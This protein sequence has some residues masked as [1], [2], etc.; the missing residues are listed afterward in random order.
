MSRT[1]RIR[2]LAVA[3]A[4]GVIVFPAWPAD[5]PPRRAV[6]ARQK[7]ELRF[8]S[9]MAGQGLWREALFRWERLAGEIPADPRLWNNIAVAREALGD[10]EGARSAYRKALDLEPETHIQANAALQARP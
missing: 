4:A 5:S 9:R 3:L 7:L 6:T 1:S 2:R 8:A 10:I